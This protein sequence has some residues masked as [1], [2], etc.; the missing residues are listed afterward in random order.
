MHHLPGG[1]HLCGVHFVD[2][3]RF[4]PFLGIPSPLNLSEPHTRALA[5]DLFWEITREIKACMFS[6]PL[7]LN[8]LSWIHYQLGGK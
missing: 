1:H 7:E 5:H 3:F 4:F 2:L 6:S 8:H